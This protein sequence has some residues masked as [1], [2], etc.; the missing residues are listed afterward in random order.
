MAASVPQIPKIV[1]FTLGSSV[2]FKEDVIDLAVVP[3][4]DTETSVLTLDG[5]LHKDIT[6]GGW[7]LVGKAVQDWDSA[8]PGLAWYAYTHKGESLAFVFNAHGSGAESAGQPKFTGTVVVS[9][10]SYGGTGNEF[11]T[12]DFSWPITG[13]LTLDAT[14]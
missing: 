14:P 7:K 8:R 10:L 6:A 3:D 5:V 13:T 1:T 11:S 4:G 9:P 12:S 2:S